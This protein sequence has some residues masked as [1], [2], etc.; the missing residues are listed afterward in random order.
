MSSNWQWSKQRLKFGGGWNF[1]WI[2]KVYFC[3]RRR[4]TRA[5]RRCLMTTN[6]CGVRTPSMWSKY[7][8][9]PQELLPHTPS[10]PYCNQLSSLT[11]VR[12]Y[13]LSLDETEPFRL[14]LVLCIY[15]ALMYFL[16]IKDIYMERDFWSRNNLPVLVPLDIV[17]VTLFI[18]N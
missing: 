10:I 3:F 1:G 15:T 5:L 6:W 12:N 17:L 4:S 11:P 8:R 9:K 16:I 7:L 18:W 13:S 2:L 14:V